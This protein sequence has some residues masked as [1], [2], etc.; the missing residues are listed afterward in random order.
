VEL[1][2]GKVEG[3]L[4]TFLR[5]I[6]LLEIVGGVGVTC[7]GWVACY[8]TGG[9]WIRSAPLWLGG[10]LLVYNLDR[11]HYDPADR[12]NTPTRFLCR[13]SLR[14]KRLIV[15]WLS[16]IALVGWSAFTGRWWLIPPLAL[17]IAALQFYSR[18]LPYIRKRLKDLPVL[19]TFIAPL[20]IAAVLVLWPV[21]ELRRNLGTREILI[22]F[23]CLIILCV[24][25]LSFDLR[26]IQGD[27]RLGTR[28]VAVLLGANWSVVFL[29]ALT[30]LATL[31]S[32]LLGLRGAASVL[33]PSS[34]VVGVGLIFW[35]FF[36]HAEAITLSF[37]ADL[38]FFLPALAL[39]VAR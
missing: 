15:I 32:P 27:L 21:L 20:L 31:M 24:N 35:A 36:S 26:D 9:S 17:V 38:L 28:T 5:Q 2:S 7:L 8:L 6:Y 3:N 29:G 19:K 25:S 34:L 18:P 11:L 4:L 14:P 37:V 39:L 33:V 23:W 30:L 22:F 12:E 1:R 10:Y 13:E 16:V